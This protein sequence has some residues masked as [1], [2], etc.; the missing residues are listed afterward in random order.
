MPTPATLSLAVGSDEILAGFMIAAGA[1]LI[2]AG[3]PGARRWLGQRKST[4]LDR[5]KGKASAAAPKRDQLAGDI[6]E[7]TRLCAAQL[8]KRAARIESLLERADV[9]IA[10]LEELGDDLAESASA[11]GQTRLGVRRVRHGGGARRAESGASISSDSPGAGAGKGATEVDP[12]AR[13][14]Y[15]LADSGKSPVEI[16]SALEEQVGKVELIL[17]LRS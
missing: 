14:V 13:E 4:G 9:A 6:E 16:A 8:D 15:Q 10:R 12:L 1:L 5:A 2:L 3:I 7:L 11:E 17:A